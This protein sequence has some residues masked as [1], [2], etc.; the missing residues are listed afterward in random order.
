MLLPDN[1][2]PEQTLYYN[3]SIVLNVLLNTNGQKL[4]IIDLYQRAND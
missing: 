1:V 4:S 3:G 2:H